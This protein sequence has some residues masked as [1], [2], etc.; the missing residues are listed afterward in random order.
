MEIE[1]GDRPIVGVNVHQADEEPVPVM[2]IDPNLE[3][4]GKWSISGPGPPAARDQ[5]RV[6]S[7]LAEVERRA[8]AGENVMPSVLDAVETG[9][10]VGEI[11]DALR[12][13]FG[14]HVEIRTL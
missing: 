9:G 10:T 14:E 6:K 3:R 13:V 12:R 8:R 11:A 4:D 1:R 7:A 2:R 5:V